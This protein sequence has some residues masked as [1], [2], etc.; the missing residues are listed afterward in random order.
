MR[1]QE[2][3]LAI[4]LDLLALNEELAQLAARS[5]A[6]HGQSALLQGSQHERRAST[7]LHQR[8]PELGRTLSSTSRYHVQL[9]RQIAVQNAQRVVVRRPSTTHCVY[10]TN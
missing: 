4:L 5:L 3:S 7:S 6:R 9:A 1:Y 2:T 10:S 8:V